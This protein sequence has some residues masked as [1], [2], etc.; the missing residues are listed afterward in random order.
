MK[1]KQRFQVTAFIMIILLSIGVFTA[2]SKSSYETTTADTMTTTEMSTDGYAGA[3][4]ESKAME[5]PASAALDMDVQADG[6]MGD[7]FVSSNSTADSTTATP[8]QTESVTN[9]SLQA[10]ADNRMYIRTFNFQIET[11]EFDA[12]ALALDNLV[13]K[14]FGFFQSTEV[15]GRAIGYDN[16]ISR[17]GIYTIRIP[18]EKAGDF[19][20]G[21]VGIGNVLDSSSYVEDVTSTYVDINARIKTLKVQEDRLIAILEK[22]TELQY[23]LELERELSSVRY[24]IESYSSSLRDLEGRVNYTTIYVTLNEVFEKTEIVTQPKT[25]FDKIVDGFMRSLK[26]VINYLENVVIFLITNIPTFILLIVNIFIIYIVIRFLLRTKFLRKMFM[27][28][29]RKKHATSAFTKIMNSNEDAD[30]EPFDANK[31]QK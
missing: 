29:D 9:A 20:K 21:L 10:Q 27:L 17:Q 25:F 11:L 12:S 18:K 6:M 2:C 1:N 19:L 8:P 28:D 7:T 3:A 22:A 15:T 26:D 4:E 31:E 30:V 14:Y 13:N 24:E 5:S 16:S 23:I